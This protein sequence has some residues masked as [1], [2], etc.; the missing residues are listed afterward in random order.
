VFADWIFFGLAGLSLFV[1]RRR[2]PVAGRDPR[3]FLTPGYPLVPGLFIFV[4]LAI[5]ISVLRS[6]P[7][8]S[9]I[10]VGVLASG[11]PAYLFWRRSA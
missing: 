9:L 8:G 3:L 4:A 10:G 1:F 6:N 11:V 7:A 2:Y 5:V